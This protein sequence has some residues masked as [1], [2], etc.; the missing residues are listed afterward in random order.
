MFAVQKQRKMPFRQFI[1]ISPHNWIMSQIPQR[2]QGIFRK[3]HHHT[4]DSADT[5]LL[6]VRVQHDC[7]ASNSLGAQLAA[8]SVLS[9]L[10]LHLT[11]RGIPYLELSVYCIYILFLNFTFKLSSLREVIKPS[12]SFSQKGGWQGCVYNPVAKL[13]YINIIIVSV[14][15]SELSIC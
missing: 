8:C 12:I 7:L 11:C 10:H 14:I 15:K 1:P 13:N 3:Q 2:N 9:C 5:V 6:G 4:A